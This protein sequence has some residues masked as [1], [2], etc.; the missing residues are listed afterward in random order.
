MGEVSIIF[1]KNGFEKTEKVKIKIDGL[2]SENRKDTNLGE[3]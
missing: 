1:S 3:N 2:K